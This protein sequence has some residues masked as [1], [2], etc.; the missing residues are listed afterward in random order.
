MFKLLSALLKQAT[1]FIFSHK[2]STKCVTESQFTHEYNSIVKQPCK[3]L[4]GR[5]SRCSSPRPVAEYITQPVPEVRGNRTHAVDQ[6]NVPACDRV[7]HDFNFALHPSTLAFLFLSL[8]TKDLL[9]L[10]ERRLK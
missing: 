10:K 3:Y 1:K 4:N 8:T 9:R 7:P 6:P 2:N 5:W